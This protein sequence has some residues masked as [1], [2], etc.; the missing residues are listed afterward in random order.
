MSARCRND[1]WR[2]YR[3]RQSNQR[4][5]AV[6]CS[7][8]FIG[9]GSGEDSVT[10]NAVYVKELEMS[11]AVVHL[12]DEKEKEE[13]GGH[14]GW[15]IRTMVFASAPLGGT[16]EQS[17][18]R[19]RVSG[20]V[21]TA[22][23]TYLPY[24]FHQFMLLGLI[25]FHA[26]GDA[27]ASVCV[28]G[29]G[30]GVLPMWLAHN[31]LQVAVTAVELDP[32]V[33]HIAQA[34]CGAA[35]SDNLRFVRQDAVTFIQDAAALGMTYDFVAVD[36]NGEESKMMAPPAAFRGDAFIEALAK[37]LGVGGMV[38]INIMCTCEESLRA[39]LRCIGR[40]FGYV[41]YLEQR[42]DQASTSPHG[43]LHGN[44]TLLCT[45]DLD[46]TLHCTRLCT[47]WVLQRVAILEEVWPCCRQFELTAKL[48][49]N[50]TLVTVLP[51]VH[52]RRRF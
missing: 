30:A 51:D 12:Y 5:G 22:D 7:T 21:V 45:Q 4:D 11:R 33:L 27:E 15:V 29:V 19:V 37:V 43:N 46:P 36:V 35:E 17:K 42:K 40:H 48:R 8:P 3:C 14:S 10:R 41:A 18:V 31:I 2:S 34:F 6:P 49:D 16:L 39:Y 50:Y 1:L 28:L 25:P 23:P 44:L 13:G 47:T 9:A 52:R 26:A 38:A 24:T 32:T 20:A